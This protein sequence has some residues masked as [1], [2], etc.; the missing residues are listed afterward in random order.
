MVKA[1]QARLLRALKEQGAV[2]VIPTN[3]EYLRNGDAHFRFRPDSDFV[4]MT[5]FAEPG[6]VAVFNPFNDEAPYTLFLRPRDK[7]KETWTGRRLGV[8]RAPEHLGCDKALPIESI[9]EHLPEALKGAETLFFPLGHGSN[10]DATLHEALAGARRLRRKGWR[11]PGIIAD[12]LR[13][14][15]E[16]RL[17]K[18]EAEIALHQEAA[19]ISSD[20]HIEAMAATKPG[21]KEYE[22]EA[23]IAYTFR[24]RGAEGPAYSSIVGGGANATILHYIENNCA[25]KA[26][27]LLLIDAGA[28]Y[29]YYAADITRTFPVSGKFSPLQRDVYDIVLASQ[30]K[31]IDAVRI[32]RRFIDPHDEA[33]RVLTQGLVDLKVLKGSVD[34]LIEEE[35]YRPYYMHKTGHWLGMDVHDTGDYY[36]GEGYFDR[37]SRPFEP[38]MITTVEPGLYFPEDDDSIPEALRGLGIRIEDDILVTRGAPR[39]LTARCPK[40]ADALEALVGSRA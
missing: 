16:M 13:V 28:E 40:D 38:G 18:D 36:E 23:L 35:A 33:V 20:A 34:G 14:F 26:G 2:A 30:L 27:E 10:L 25:L 1:R 5:G 21:L 32:G 4:Y 11:T 9:S 15:G 3:P 17:F 12:P 8:E 39:V 22:I 6:A 7:E 19:D 37:P 29:Q 31:S 24:R